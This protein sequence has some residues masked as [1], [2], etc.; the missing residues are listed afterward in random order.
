MPKERKCAEEIYFIVRNDQSYIVVCI[1]LY[2]NHS[3]CELRDR[4]T[5]GEF[6]EPR[7]FEFRNKHT[8][9]GPQGTD[10]APKVLQI[11][12]VLPFAKHLFHDI[13]H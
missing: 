2:C 1:Y 6:H 3:L 4:V 13:L 12:E 5:S 7:L 8:H 9:T 10:I 11:L